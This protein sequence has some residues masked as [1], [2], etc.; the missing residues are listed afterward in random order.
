[1]FDFLHVRLTPLYSDTLV[2][3]NFVLIKRRKGLEGELGNL[4]F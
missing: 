3:A 2:Q 4:Q 1:M